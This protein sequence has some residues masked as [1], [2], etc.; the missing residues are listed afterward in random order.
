MWRDD[1]I[2]TSTRTS[3]ADQE[4]F[5]KDE[6]GGEYGS[7]NSSSW[8]DEETHYCLQHEQFDCYC[9]WPRS[10]G[11]DHPNLHHE[12]T[13]TT[14]SLHMDGTTTSSYSELEEAVADTYFY[15][16]RDLSMEGG[17]S[18]MSK[19]M[20]NESLVEAADTIKQSKHDNGYLNSSSELDEADEVLMACK[21]HREAT[22][23]ALY[24]DPIDLDFYPN[25]NSFISSHESQW[26]DIVKPKLS[27]IQRH[28]LMVDNDK[29][30][31]ADEEE[32]TPQSLGASN[33]R[34]PLAEHSVKVDDEMQ[35]LK[36][37]LTSSTLDFLSRVEII[38][39][40]LRELYTRKQDVQR[41][42][43]NGEGPIS[44]SP[45]RLGISKYDQFED[46][47]DASADHYG[48]K[49]TPTA[50]TGII[51]C[52]VGDMQIAK[53]H[54]FIESGSDQECN[55][56][57]EEIFRPCAAEPGTSQ[58]HVKSFSSRTRALELGYQQQQKQQD[59]DDDDLAI[60]YPLQQGDDGHTDNVSRSHMDCSTPLPGG[61]YIVDYFKNPAHTHAG[62]RLKSRILELEGHVHNLCAKPCR[63]AIL[64]NVS[65][66]AMNGQNSIEGDRAPTLAEEGEHL[67]ELAKTCKAQ[68]LLPIMSR[69]KFPDENENPRE[70]NRNA[71]EKT[72]GIFETSKGKKALDG[73]L[74][75]SITMSMPGFQSRLQEICH[76]KQV[77]S[78]FSSLDDALLSSKTLGVP[79]FR[80]VE[81]SQEKQ[82]ESSL[83]S[84]ER[85][86]LPSIEGGQI[87]L[88]K[89]ASIPVPRI[90]C[91][92]DFH[93]S[94]SDGHMVL[95]ERSGVIERHKDAN[96]ASIVATS[97]PDSNPRNSIQS[98]IEGLGSYADLPVPSNEL[99]KILHNWQRQYQTPPAECYPSSIEGPIEESYSRNKNILTKTAGMVDHTPQ[100]SYLSQYVKTQ[101]LRP[102]KSNHSYK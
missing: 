20:S 90:K 65:E 1:A 30:Q 29:N 73:A 84:L 58:N 71:E 56:S 19:S 44:S 8:D 18:Q 86:M 57:I 78:R 99:M 11:K 6:S 62:V 46:A 76:K 95:T 75:R 102:L 54:K 67:R 10:R 37:C 48:L 52:R 31:E 13:G 72:G 80:S 39:S 85:S 77:E 92:E 94:A 53:Q 9:S 47:Q 26:E 34:I 82:Q 100:N 35:K 38:Q 12:S 45:P 27:S 70:T 87:A 23:S 32:S 25:G 28:R 69:Q 40:T 50:Q 98:Q 21:S 66:S 74:S 60:N 61:M 36:K 55:I 79:S 42:Y 81:T 83:T 59:D 68:Q 14:S 93:G 63:S 97:E 16:P 89:A 3:S 15:Y 96:I 41:T 22:E 88:R 24:P 33:M 17:F 91:T 5:L 43:K 49:L 64:Q 51:T 4:E 2:Y 7:S 101:A